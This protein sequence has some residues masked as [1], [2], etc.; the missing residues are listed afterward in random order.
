M[1]EIKTHILKS[2]PVIEQI[3][4]Q[5]EEGTNCLISDLDNTLWYDFRVFGHASVEELKKQINLDFLHENFNKKEQKELIKKV[6]DLFRTF[7][8]N[9][10]ICSRGDN[11][12]KDMERKE[13]IDGIIKD[14][15]SFVFA[16]ENVK[17]PDNTPR[18][19]LW[20]VSERGENKLN[21]D[22]VFFI[23][24]SIAEH[25]HNINYLKANAVNFKTYNAF[26]LDWNKEL[27]PINKPLVEQFKS[28]NGLKFDPWTCAMCTFKQNTGNNC[29]ICGNKKALSKSEAAP[30]LEPSR[31]FSKSVAA[32]KVSGKTSKSEAA[33]SCKYCTLKNSFD[34]EM[35]KLCLK[36]K[37]SGKSK[38]KR[39]SKRRSK[40]RSKKKRKSKKKHSQK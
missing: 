25:I 2:G 1:V 21:F 20:F 12:S 34:I 28:A 10:I 16:D 13:V 35:C 32:P 11:T 5:I 31:R 39:R 19:K 27:H 36:K 15:A 17:C 29:D 6:D 22:N 38:K 24:D 40:K 23:D 30:T 37:D 3:I 18:S 33:W 8:E 7:R 4:S 9:F 26:F 14:R